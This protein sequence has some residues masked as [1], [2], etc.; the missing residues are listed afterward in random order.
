MILSSEERPELMGLQLALPGNFRTPKGGFRLPPVVPKFNTPAF[1]A[2]T[3]VWVLA[4]LLAIAGPVLGFHYRY[5]EKR[6]NSQLLLG[7]RAGFA[8]SPRDATRVRFTVGPQA[9]TAG[10]VAGDHIIAIYGLPLPPSMP[11]NEEALAEHANDPAYITMGNLLYG[12]DE[13]QVPLTV[14][15][16]NGR[17]RDVTVTTSEHHIDAGAKSLRVSP[18]LLSFI[19]LLH[20]V[21]YPFLLWAAWLLHRRN[22]RDV[23]SSFF[24]LAV[25]LNIAAEQPS[26]VF[27]ASIGVPHSVNVAIYDLGN[28]LLLTGIMLFPHGNL[29]WRVV[30]LIAC[31]P[32]L[33]FLQGLIYQAFFVCFMVIGVVAM[34]QRL[35]QTGS[36][37][38]RQ[39]IRWALLGISAYALL[40]CISIVCDFSKWSTTSFGQQLLVEIAAGITFALAMLFL[41]L[42][43]L[44]A[45]LRYRLYD[46]EIAIGRSVNFAVI[47]LGVAAIFAAAGDALK[48][49]VYNYSGN[50]NSE[51]PIIFAAALATIMVNPIQD[52]VQRWSEKRFQ[53]NLFLLRE[54][55]P[56]SV[57]DMRET[58]SLGEMLKEILA[59]IDRGVRAVRGAVIVNGCVVSARGLST[60]EVE[61]WRSSVFAQDYRSDVCEPSDRQFPIRVPLVPSS[62]E[63]EPI[64]F[65]LVGPRPDGSIPSR[66]EQKA[67]DEV[68]EEIAR[69]I[70]TVIRRE[71]REAEVAELIADNSRRIAALE[72]MLGAGATSTGK[73]SRGTA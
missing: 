54:D 61:T 26:S 59:Q 68:S 73:R 17:V 43:L 56:Q 72:A 37:E 44:I 20:I 46:A 40:R 41:Q 71:A 52:R 42:G 8:V 23:V 31:L 70:R 12:T 53:K 2:F 34:T 69:A 15:D 19:D 7:S 57:R 35:K 10:I 38:Q 1:W 49:I 6:N 21:F 39:Q 50:T 33:F 36:S 13:S 25:L 4:F 14:R 62:D 67:L 16:P 47:T 28:V 55:L 66:S 32:L 63:E 11:M 64:G 45:L 9:E 60:D 30:G 65:L 3:I 48:Q 58:A 51:G 27:L 22:P 18:R 29:S 5:T 24:S